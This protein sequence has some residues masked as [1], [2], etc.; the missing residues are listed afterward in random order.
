MGKKEKHETENKKIEKITTAVSIGE[1]NSQETEKIQEEPSGIKTNNT[2]ASLDAILREV[3]SSQRNWPQQALSAILSRWK[4]MPRGGWP[5]VARYYCDKFQTEISE[6]LFKITAK[7]ILR[8]QAGNPTGVRKFN[9][10]RRKEETQ[11]P[12]CHLQN[13]L[14]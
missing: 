12:R 1:N 14:S 5:K 13:L 10:K 9:Q 2:L 8:N 11:S 3:Q 6:T 7:E 4:Q